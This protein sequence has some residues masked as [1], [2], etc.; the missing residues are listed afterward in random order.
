M[1]WRDDIRK[2]VLKDCRADFRPKR[3]DQRFCCPRHAVN[4]RVARHRSRYIDAPLTVVPEKPLQPAQS[5]AARP[6]EAATPYFNPHGPNARGS[7]RRRLPAR[8]LRRRLSQASVM[9]RPASTGMTTPRWLQNRAATALKDVTRIRRELR[10][11]RRLKDAMRLKRELKQ[12]QI[13]CAYAQHWVMLT[14]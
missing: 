9:S 11:A 12:A 13:E 7:P 1:T 2:C 5:P 10:K 8:I 3:E 14:E 4:D 6:A